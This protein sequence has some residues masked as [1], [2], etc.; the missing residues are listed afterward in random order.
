MNTTGSEPETAAGLASAVI[1]E[2]AARREAGREGREVLFADDLLPG[3]GGEQMGMREGLAKGGAFTFWILL[4]LNALDELESG[5]LNLLAPDIRDTFGVSDGTITF[6]AA[7]SGAFFVLGAYPMGWLADRYRRGP[8]VGIASALFTC[9]VALTGMAVNAFMLFCTRF[10]VG[11]SKANT[12]TVHQS[13]IGDTYPIAIRGRLFA[14]YWMCGRTV[15]AVAPVIIGGIVLLA[16]GDDGWRWAFFIVGLPVL[17]FALVAFRLPEP[18]RGQWEKSDVLGSVV[19]EEDPSPIS[20]EAAFARLLRIRTIRSVLVGFSALGFLLFTLGVQSSLYMEEEFG[21][22]AFGRG[23]VFSVAGVCAAAFLPFVGTRFDRLYR[24]SPERAIRYIGLLLLPNAVLVPVQ[25]LMPNEYWF[26]AVGVPVQVLFAAAFAM[27]SPTILAVVPYRLRGLGNALITTCI[28]LFGGVG[29]ALVAAIL[30]DAYGTR[31]AVICLAFPSLF[32]GAQM[33]MRGA[34]TIRHDL[35]SVVAELQEELA[36]HE[37]QKQAP[38]DIPALQLSDID[39][40]YGQVQV[41]FNLSFSVARGETLAVLGTNGAGKSTALRVATGLAVPER[42]AVRLNG[43]TITYA[44]PE[45]RG[46]MGIQMLPGGQGVFPTLTVRDN[47]L[48]GAYRYRGDPADVDRRIDGVLELFPVLAERQGEQAL[49]L[50]GGQQQILALGRV[51]LHEPEVLII[52]ELSLGLAPA[53]V[54]DLLQH[55]E[56]LKASGQ[57]MIIVEQSLNVAVAIADRAV[58]LEKGELRFEGPAQ[59]LVERDD[60]AR[61][62]FFGIEGG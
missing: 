49:N 54:Q 10:G 7:A 62:V 9:F 45:Q 34:G 40:S 6:I 37:R 44:T 5:A 14:V 35:S 1:D 39:F 32:I 30:V 11:V 16:G 21:L 24:R 15:F 55:L 53:V 47:L 13:L 57:T 46:S 3:V 42:G 43:R 22:G 60:L 27:V 2:E 23:V 17:V 51:M 36:E 50:S 19:D 20:V 25:F 61:A 33:L 18:T 59:D 31:T 56:R 52:D 26:A 41:L 58:F 4:T 48:V 38:E 12:I 8:I 28:F 29:G